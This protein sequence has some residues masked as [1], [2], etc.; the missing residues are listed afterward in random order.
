MEK[1]KKANQKG[2]EEKPRRC[3]GLTPSSLLQRSP[4]ARRP[5]PPPRI[6]PVL[7]LCAEREPRLCRGKQGLIKLERNF[8]QLLMNRRLG[9]RPS[10]P[11]GPGP[12]LPFATPASLP[13]HTFFSSRPLLRPGRLEA[14]VRA[15]PRRR[16]RAEPAGPGCLPQRPAILGSWRRPRWRRQP[17]I[18]ERS[19]EG[20]AAFFLFFFFG[21]I[22]FF[23]RESWRPPSN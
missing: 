6:N 22:F 17:G 13:P 3:S 7:G 1:K 18:R 5:A 2:R 9:S 20:P 8:S 12:A 21:G 10:P 23:L 11:P 14:A 15:S 16:S 4:E 19:L